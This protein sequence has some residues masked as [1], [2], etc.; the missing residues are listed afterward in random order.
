MSFVPVT[1]PATFRPAV[2]P[3]EGV[4]EFSDERRTI[5][6]PIR[7]ALP[8]LTKAHARDDVHPSVGLLSG[9]V[10]LGMRLV[11]AGKF[12]P[13]EAGRSWRASP[14]D[15]AD[16][17]RVEMLA[18][19]RSYDDV[20]EQTAQALV[21]EVLDAVSDAMPRSAPRS[22]A[23]RASTPSS[24][25]SGAGSQRGSQRGGHGFESRLR[26]R[27]A[28]H[29][30]DADADLPQLVTISLRVEAD[31][32]ELVAGAVRLVLQ[33]HDEQN[34]LHLC[35]A[36]VLFTE[37]G[38]TASHGFGERARTHASIALR[39]AA[40]VWPVLDRLLELRVPDEITLDT[41]ELVSLLE[42]GVGALKDRGIDVLWPRS[43]GRDLTASAVLDRT[44][45]PG[46]AGKG[47]AKGQ[48]EEPLHEGLFGTAAMFAFKWQLALHGDPLT[49]EEMDELAQATAPILKLRGHWTVV[50]P[51]MARR[52]RKRLVRTVKP[53]QAVAAAL[54]GVVQL[55]PADDRGEVSQTQVVVGATL[56][57]VRE[58]L[59]TAA[60]RDPVEP[61]PHLRAD[62]RDYQR[63]GLTWLADLTSLGLGA[64]LADDMGLG[65]TV[66]LIALHLH[67][68]DA[69]ATGPTLVVCP[70][71]LL[72]NWEAEIQRFAPGVPVR[73]FHGT[74]R[75]L[76]DLEH[77][78]GFVLTTYGTMR[79][80]HATLEQVPWDLVVADEA[81]HVK[82]PQS[83][84][85]RALRAIESQARVALTGTPVENNLTEL[86]AI[87]DWATPGL[88]GSRNAFRKVWAGP[89]ESGLEPTKARQFA[90]LIGPFLLRR[91]KSDPGIA[92]ELPAKT[93]TDHPLGLTQE[94]VVLYESF[95]RDS[96]RRIEEADE[97]TR[98]GLVLALLT[99]LKQICNHPAHF[100]KQSNGRLAGRSEKLDLLDELI[101][102]VLAEDGAVLLFTQYVAMARLLET[103]F[104][105]A[106][107]PHQFLH[108][109]TPVRE[110][111]AMVRRFQAGEVP[112]FLLSLKAGGTGLNLTRADHVIHVDRWW[113]PAV[114]DQA[115]DR[116]Y[117]IGQT[118]PVQV[119]RL[120][121]Q[122]TIEEKVAEL[123][124]RKRALADSVLGG[125]EAA[126]TELSNDEL[127]DL[128]T[129]RRP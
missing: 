27:L 6:L 94:Q 25:S 119:H 48:R 74:Q 5:S 89:I 129:L 52:A 124:T 81:Q 21:R 8:V 110:R 85:A 45:P 24:P 65:K 39:A 54:T 37:S 50:D 10:L 118:R 58:Q 71:S 7:A 86:W 75:S 1:G 38:P 100:L 46:G 97:E 61:S 31:E 92:P 18:R 87:L 70:A 83:S 103:H 77:D 101:G 63:H 44:S 55:E 111:D 84:T 9:A 72:G 56:L 47:K 40:D 23:H 104:A 20:D 66:T 2:P 35:D 16:T 15:A 34:P 128:V 4:V 115:T 59:L 42:D 127:R 121:T 112:V 76:E 95:V 91:R 96:M 12:E 120:I 123:L 13:D 28:R 117:R 93:E 29:R 69:G 43:L 80:D 105:K 122:G 107:I 11:A 108:G 17:D 102:T 67:R 32:E 126:L 106:S 57:K 60:T 33:V 62:L 114:E 41:D 113:N 73:R 78:G 79:V 26:Q 51:A 36:A 64:C 19:S 125:G 68:R 49:P 14:L 3:R 88:L 82:N 53:V 30:T 98:R 109:G 22:T 116:A 99:G 90:D